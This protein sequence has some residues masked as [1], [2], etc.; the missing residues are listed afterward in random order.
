MFEHVERITHLIVVL[1]QII[2]CFAITYL[3]TKD[4]WRKNTK[5]SSDIRENYRSRLDKFTKVY[6][7]PTV[8]MKST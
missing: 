3:K 1:L 4:S 8:G 6:N 2:V 7:R 5:Y